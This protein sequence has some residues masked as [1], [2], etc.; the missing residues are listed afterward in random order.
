[1]KINSGRGT[2]TS[3]V[4]SKSL[5]AH[6]GEE[7]RAVYGNTIKILCPHFS[8]LEAK[9]DWFYGMYFFSAT[10][11]QKIW[12]KINNYFRSSILFI[13]EVLYF[14]LYVFIV[15]Y[16]LTMNQKSFKTKIMHKINIPLSIHY[17]NKL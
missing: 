8:T 12:N 11:F 2:R 10:V 16:S 4:L 14:L 1:M 7:V 5:T 9:I 13:F 17:L 6:I 3:S 15:R